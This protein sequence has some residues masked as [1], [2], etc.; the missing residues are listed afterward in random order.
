MKH[1]EADVT[2]AVSSVSR[3]SDAGREGTKDT[4]TLEMAVV[5]PSSRLL[6]CPSPDASSP[7]LISGARSVTYTSACK[8]PAGLGRAGAPVETGQHCGARAGCGAQGHGGGFHERCTE[9]LA[10]TRRL[11]HPAGVW[12]VTLRQVSATSSGHILY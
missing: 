7:W 11:V 3:L 12:S 1:C 5:Y 6:S 10:L 8:W 2:P 9:A 4:Q